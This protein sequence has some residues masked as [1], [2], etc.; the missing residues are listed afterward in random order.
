LLYPF[1]RPETSSGIELLSESMSDMS[2]IEIIV[3]SAGATSLLSRAHDPLGRP[4][5]THLRDVPSSVPVYSVTYAY[6]GKGRFHSVSSSVDAVSSVVN[7]SYL[8][9]S[10]LISGWDNGTLSTVRSYEPNRNLITAI[11][12]HWGSTPISVYAYENDELARRTRRVDNASVT[13]EFGYNIRSEV[14]E[15]LMGTNTYDYAYDPIGNRQAYT[16]NGE[17]LAYLANAL[18]QYT[19]ITN[20]GLRV[21]AYDL[22]GNLTNDSVFAYTWDGENRLTGVT[23]SGVAA[24]YEYDYMSRRYRKTV[25]GVTNTFLYDGWNLIQEVSAS[26]GAVVTNVYTW[27]LDLSGSMQG[28]GGIGGLL[29]VT[30]ST[31]SGT[32]TYFSCFDANGN[33]TDYVG[34]NGTVAAHYEYGPFGGTIE[35]SGTKADD[36]RFRF[37]TKY[38]DDETALYYYGYRYYNPELGRWVN[39]DPMSENVGPQLFNFVCNNSISGIDLLGLADFS[40]DEIESL[41]LAIEVL[42]AIYRNRSTIGESRAATLMELGLR[43]AAGT[44]LASRPISLEY[45]LHFLSSAGTAKNLD[46]GTY[47]GDRKIKALLVEESVVRTRDS[48]RS[49]SLGGSADRSIAGHI[50][51]DRTYPA[52]ED[53]LTAVG[54]AQISYTMRTRCVAV[55]SHGITVGMRAVFWI[56]DTYDFNAEHFRIDPRLPLI[57]TRDIM[58]FLVDQGQAKVFKVRSKIYA[59]SHGRTDD[60]IRTN[61]SMVETRPDATYPDH[62]F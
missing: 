7:Y 36:F 38:H 49:F 30:R 56:N 54:H 35:S 22:D 31:S 23:G 15:A 10:G 62:S 19:A 33:L 46:A 1:S 43:G 51:G 50:D 25:S 8:P 28:A 6:D 20:G 13:N 48:R 27:G 34:T 4:V 32:A 17:A 26:A 45:F 61:F 16:N 14:I 5:G 18:N 29:S 59:K 37:S 12:N 42:I 44:L 52:D 47:F 24:T 2:P 39:R 60:Q 53:I 41:R 9:N 11:S 57:P 40:D 58:A 3:S 55:P 21:L